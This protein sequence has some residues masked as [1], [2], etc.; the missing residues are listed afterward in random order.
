[1]KNFLTGLVFGF[2][3]GIMLS[4]RSGRE[5]RAEISSAYQEIR[6]RLA[7]EMSRLKEITRETYEQVVDS[8]TSAY[9]E[10]SKITS[11]EAAA[12]GKELKSGFERMKQAHLEVQQRQGV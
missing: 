5:T 6:D 9:V 8:L 12:I 10:T 2:V 7:E 4:P 11:R 3:A 1:M